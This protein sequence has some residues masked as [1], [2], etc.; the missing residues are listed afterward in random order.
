M[1]LGE[2]KVCPFNFRVKA[3]GV[4]LEDN[5]YLLH[6]AAYILLA[7]LWQKGCELPPPP[8][9]P[10]PNLAR[11]VLER[12]V[13]GLKR[14]EMQRLLFSLSIRNW[15]DNTEQAQKDCMVVDKG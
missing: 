11:Y 4:C 14:P 7:L 15:P 2:C 6:S 13:T 8:T 1:G 5:S 12:C 3:C 10:L 9:H